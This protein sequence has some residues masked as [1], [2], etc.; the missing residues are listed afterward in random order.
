[1]KLYRGGEKQ[2]RSTT[3]VGVWLTDDR[4]VAEWYGGVRTYAFDD[5]DDILDLRGLGVGDGEDPDSCE[6]LVAELLAAGVSSAESFGGGW[7]EL[8]Q[9]C[10]R[11]AFRD[12]VLDAG[13]SMVACRQWHA[14]MGES[15]YDS[16]LALDASRLHLLSD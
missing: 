4:S 9:L 7:C 6:S 13:Y 15:P 2:A 8:Y 3:L 12:A 5:D 10:E 1:M 11:P 14:D 16:W